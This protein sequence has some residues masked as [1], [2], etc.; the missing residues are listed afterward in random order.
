MPSD[1]KVRLVQEIAKV[2]DGYSDFFITENKGLS[3]ADITELRSKLRENGA[4]YQVMKNNLLKIA[5]NNK[6]I[7]GLD[8]FLVGPNAILFA[9]DPV[10]SAKVL[11]DYLKDKAKK[12]KLEIKAGFTEGRVVDKQYIN[13][14]AS[15]PSREEL[16]SKLL[17]TM[18]NPATRLVKVLKNPLQKFAFA[19]KAIADKK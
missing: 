15:L 16:L 3:V 6:S 17:G 9:E 8:S 14:L 1:K 12:D 19:L 10:G 7:D 18:K 2:L 11:R 5:L 4:V 13:S